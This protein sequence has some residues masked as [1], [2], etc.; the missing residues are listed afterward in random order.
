MT[1]EKRC[2]ICGKPFK[3]AIHRPDQSVCLSAEC[4]HKR[5][6]ENMKKWRAKKAD[7][8]DSVSWK[9]SCRLKSSEWRKK[10]QAYL[11]LYREENKEKRGEYMKEY[12]RKYRKLAKLN[13][14]NKEDIAK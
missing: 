4:Q 1:E 9:E 10:H 12:M 2:G 3:P 11:K 5:Q 6:L 14:K 7:S 13:G 8:P